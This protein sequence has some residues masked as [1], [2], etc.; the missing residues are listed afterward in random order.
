M[1][2]FMSLVLSFLFSV[3]SLTILDSLFNLENTKFHDPV[4]LVVGLLSFGVF[5]RFFQYLNLVFSKYVEID[6]GMHHAHSSSKVVNRI[7]WN[8][9][10]FPCVSIIVL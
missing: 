5:W 10:G 6:N 8:W 1:K 3:I 2:L 9:I 7:N 4:I